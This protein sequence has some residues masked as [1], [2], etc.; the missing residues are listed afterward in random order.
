MEELV[1]NA[2][3]S[4]C[5]WFGKTPESLSKEEKEQIKWALQLHAELLSTRDESYKKLKKELFDVS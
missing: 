3:N 5:K 2:T 4:F 1:K